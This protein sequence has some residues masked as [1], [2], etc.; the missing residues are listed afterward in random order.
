[1]TSPVSLH[2]AIDVDTQ[3]GVL[4]IVW[5][6]DIRQRFDNATLRRHCRC[7]DCKALRLRTGV[8]LDIPPHTTIREI[9]M[10][11][12]YA[13]QFVFS[14]GHERG[15]FPWVF[16]REIPTLALQS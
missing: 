10:V 5:D 2:N 12:H 1:M 15:I 16:I 9:R 13:A 4:D 8:E 6:D 11:G 7:A 14:D 3:V